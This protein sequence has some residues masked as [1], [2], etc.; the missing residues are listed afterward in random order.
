MNL[1]FLG[2]P[3]AGKGTVAG[4]ISESYQITQIS[5]GDIF[6]EAVKMGTELGSKVKSIMERGELV[7]DSLTVDLV[8]ERLSRND[9]LKGFIL[10]GFPRTIPQADALSEFQ[11]I[12]RVINFVLDDNIVI[13]RLSGRRVCRQCGAIYHI[14]N[15]PSKVEGVCDVCGGELYTRDDDQIDSI[16][17]R[18]QVYKEQT[19]PL[20]RYYHDEELLT[21]IDSSDSVESSAAQIK[22]IL[23][24]L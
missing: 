16:E 17:K 23:Q 15:L 9:T 13:R 24:E 21:D 4:V 3:G 6:R 19:E 14:E 8:K 20:I 2:S 10:D 18:L 11:R 7:P 1:V 12:D 5:T 22:R